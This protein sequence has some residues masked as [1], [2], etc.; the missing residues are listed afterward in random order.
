M[1]EDKAKICPQLYY[2]ASLLL[3]LLW[4]PLPQCRE[5]WSEKSEGARMHISPECMRV[6]DAPAMEPT[7]T[8]LAVTRAMATTCR[9]S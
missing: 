1:S 7:A 6:P 3:S 8:N 2:G 5:H 9:T 4:G